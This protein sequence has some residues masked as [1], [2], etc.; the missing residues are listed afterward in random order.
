MKRKVVV[1]AS[2]AL[3]WI[4]G[5]KEE[6]IK[7]ARK[8][9][10]RIAD[11]EIE[12]WAPNFLAL[13]MLNILIRKRK[14]DP[15]LAVK[16][17]ETVMGKLKIKDLDVGKLAQWKELMEKYEISGYDSIYLQL[18]GELGCKVV[19]CDKKLTDIKELVEEL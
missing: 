9:Y 14:A 15:D 6:K 12:G 17:I 10:Q 4:P 7:E 13:E 1:D 16:G 2:V 11:G 18:A 5:P 3:K 8:M 19:S